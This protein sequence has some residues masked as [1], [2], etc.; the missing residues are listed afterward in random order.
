MFTQLVC[1][2]SVSII[3]FLLRG[4]IGCAHVYKETHTMSRDNSP[5]QLL[6]CFIAY[7]L[8]TAAT[9]ILGICYS[10]KLI[11]ARAHWFNTAAMVTLI[12]V[13]LDL[14]LEQKA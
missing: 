14:Q 1:L 5:F 3:E 6:V 12:D 7:F 9:L 2:T 13:G 4:D 8:Y 11:G 10:H